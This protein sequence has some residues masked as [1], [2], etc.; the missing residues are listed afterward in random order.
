V[1][2]DCT[3][4]SSRS[5]R[6]KVLCQDED[7]EDKWVSRG[8]STLRDRSQCECPLQHSATLRLMDNNVYYIHTM[9][10]SLINSFGV[11]RL[12]VTPVPGH[13]APTHPSS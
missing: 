5:W 2:D 10:Q 12:V 3:N 8:C 1:I 13:Q 4:I 7:D 9:R 11:L 6:A